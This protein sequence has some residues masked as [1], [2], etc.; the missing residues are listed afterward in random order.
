M[1]EPSLTGKLFK[2][3]EDFTFHY[4][5][6]IYESTAGVFLSLFFIVYSAAL[7][8]KIAHT[9]L[10]NKKV[11]L[12]D[13]I[14]PFLITS[15]L[16]VILG[17]SLYWESWI[18]RPIYDLSVYLATLTAS[19]TTNFK[20]SGG[21]VG[22]L[23]L[24]DLRL[25]EVVFSPCNKVMGTLG[26]TEVHLWI[27][28][29][30]IEALY[31]FV[32]F[33]FLALMVESLFRFITFFAISPLIITALFF[34]QT[35][36]ISL[37]GF[38]SLTQGFLSMFMAG[39]AMGLTIAILADKGLLVLDKGG[40]TDTGWIFSESYFSL[41]LIALVSISFHLKAPKVAANLAGVDDGP[42]AAA[43]VAG[44]G[45]AA[46]MSVKGAAGRVM[47]RLGRGAA[48]HVGKKAGKAY[49]K[50]WDLV[51]PLAGDSLYQKITGK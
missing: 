6:T 23:H 12:E 27:G 48:G 20:A 51:P 21:I 13:F 37:A 18:V 49:D 19:L 42:G 5:K 29:L 7:L 30:I 45:T 50:A 14:K 2:T 9:A 33:L 11:G 34:P 32:W 22:M 43:A 8:W 38:K 16:S 15:C 39:V 1:I 4:G 3:L 10:F 28:L 44:L 26:F 31:V 40:N 35:R 25:N 41:L 17:T 47:G 46:A 24:V 36:P